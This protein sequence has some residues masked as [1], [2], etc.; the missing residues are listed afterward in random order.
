M[1]AKAMMLPLPRGFMLR[2]AAV[3]RRKVPLRFSETTRSNSSSEMSRS[4]LRT[5]MAGVQT[6]TSRSGSPAL[7][8]LHGFAVAHVEEHRFRASSG[9]LIAGATFFAASRLRSP[10]K[11]WAP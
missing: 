2:P 3:M 8:V 5:L 11:T 7:I 1:L 6:R 4:G 9:G 10:Q